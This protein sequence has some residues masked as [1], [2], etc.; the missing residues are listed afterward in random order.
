[1]L[2]QSRARTGKI[3]LLSNGHLTKI[4]ETVLEKDTS[5]TTTNSKRRLLSFVCGKSKELLV[6]KDVSVEHLTTFPMSCS[7]DF[8]GIDGKSLILRLADQKVI[9]ISNALGFYQVSK[10]PG[11]VTR[12]HRQV[13]C[14]WLF[15]V[16]EC[17]GTSALPDCVP[18]QRS[19]SCVHR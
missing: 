18:Y 17:N 5:G 9:S 3:T 16:H 14:C 10:R 12:H 8:S 4:E 1:M 7:F 15:E 13:L 19:E 11:L 6:S 2:F